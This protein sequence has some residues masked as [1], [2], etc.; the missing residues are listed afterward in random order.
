MEQTKSTFYN[1]ARHMQCTYFGEMSWEYVLFVN[2]N[3][4]Y[5]SKPQFILAH[6]DTMD[7]EVVKIFF[8]RGVW[9]YHL[10]NRAHSIQKGSVLATALYGGSEEKDGQSHL[11]ERRQEDMDMDPWML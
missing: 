2:K 3:R 8:V 10:T 4:D 6:E 9:C 1:L 11:Q 5:S 7:C